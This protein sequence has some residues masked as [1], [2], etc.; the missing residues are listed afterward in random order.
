MFPACPLVARLLDFRMPIPMFPACLLA[1]PHS[2]S[3]SRTPMP[4]RISAAR[5]LFPARPLTA[6]DHS[7]HAR[8]LFPARPFTRPLAVSRMTVHCARPFTAHPLA[9]SRTTTHCAHPFTACPLAVSRTT[10]H[11]A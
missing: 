3:V 1:F 6:H 10:A 2:R 8:S 7:P 5:S 9:V 11:C 4:A